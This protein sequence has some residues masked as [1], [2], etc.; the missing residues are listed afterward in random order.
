ML[1]GQTRQ[2]RPFLG[3]YTFHG[4]NSVPVACELD[5]KDNAWGIEQVAK[6]AG[7]PEERFGLRTRMESA[8]PTRHCDFSC[9]SARH[10]HMSSRRKRLETRCPQFHPL[11]ALHLE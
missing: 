6:A 4:T 11:W 7:T 9:A 8:E 1:C 2:L 3:S 5:T 10:R